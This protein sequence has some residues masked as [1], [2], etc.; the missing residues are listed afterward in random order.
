MEENEFNLENNDE[1]CWIELNPND[2]NSSAD[3]EYNE[4][5]KEYPNKKIGLKIISIPS[6]FKSTDYSKYS[7][8][9][10]SNIKTKQLTITNCIFNNLLF[11]NIEFDKLKLENC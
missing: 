7:I 6:E 8:V 10:I 2:F 3:L 5:K 4:I 9:E 1:Y 11:K